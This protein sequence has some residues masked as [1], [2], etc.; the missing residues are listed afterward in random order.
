MSWNKKKQCAIF[1]PLYRCESLIFKDLL[2]SNSAFLK[3][4][5]S[6]TRYFFDALV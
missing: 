6:F 3:K 2:N 4:K 1:V 5:L